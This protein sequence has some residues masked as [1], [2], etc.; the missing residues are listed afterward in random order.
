M[1]NNILLC[2]ICAVV[3]TG[4]MYPPFAQLLFG[5]TISVGKPFFDATTI[6][7]TLPLLGAMAF[8]TMLPWKRAQMSP[9][10]H[11]LRI[12]GL[13]AVV[14]L[15]VACWSLSGPLPILCAVGA[16]WVIGASVTDLTGRLGVSRLSLAHSWARARSLPRSAFGAALAH[17]GAGVT[18]LG[19]CGMSQAQHAIVDVKVGQT[20]TLAGYEWTL[21]DVRDAQGPNYRAMIADIAIRRHGH[22]VTVLHPSKRDFS[23]QHQTTTEVAI[24]TNLLA[25]LY[26]VIG[27]RHGTGADTTYV[28]RLHYNPL[29]PWMWL[30]GLIMAIGGGLSL[31]DRR[32]RVG[33]PKKAASIRAEATS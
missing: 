6:P 22:L 10:L 33:A 9:L 27:D 7:L 11:R 26:G 21:L 4:T 12:A 23:S 32:L 18:V 5:R 30:G 19:L 1:L 28:L 3:V 24:R 17:I 20:E 2:S 25:D 13:L 14:A 8:G 15:G 16:V 31:S 29:A